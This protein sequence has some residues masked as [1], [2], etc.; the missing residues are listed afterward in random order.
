MS[1]HKK[2]PQEL[3]LSSD[4]GA[5]TVQSLSDPFQYVFPVNSASETNL[6]SNISLSSTPSKSPLFSTPV[7]FSF[8]H[9]SGLSDVIKTGPLGKL[10]DEHIQ[11]AL[12][13]LWKYWMAPID[14]LM[15]VLGETFQDGF[16]YKTNLFSKGSKLGV[17]LNL[18]I[19]DHD[20]WECLKE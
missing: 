12:K 18:V 5:S 7:E 4:C 1:K 6:S 13:V 15:H 10:P 2:H 9:T 17:L 3:P 8:I 11:E 20:G 19:C 16:Q 14:L